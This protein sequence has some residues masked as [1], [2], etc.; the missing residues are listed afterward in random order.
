M[1]TSSRTRARDHLP[2]STEERTPD[3]STREA[4]GVSRWLIGS[5][6]RNSRTVWGRHST[7]ICRDSAMA[8]ER[9]VRN[10]APA[11]DNHCSIWYLVSVSVSAVVRSARQAR[12]G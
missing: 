7:R 8:C 4:P 1:G 3:P 2:S 12:G 11:R 9:C 6:S 5:A 10:R